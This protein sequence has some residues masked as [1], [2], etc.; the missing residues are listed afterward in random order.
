M[1]VARRNNGFRKVAKWIVGAAVVAGA[2][3]G[4]VLCNE[5]SEP[6]EAEVGEVK[7]EIKDSNNAAKHVAYADITFEDPKEG[8]RKTVAAVTE[9]ERL[10]QAPD[11]VIF[12]NVVGRQYTNRDIDDLV[13]RSGL[14]GSKSVVRHEL[15]FRRAQLLREM[16]RFNTILE[17]LPKEIAVEAGIFA[18]YDKLPADLAKKVK[19]HHFN[20]IH[21]GL[22]EKVS[23]DLADEMMKCDIYEG[24]PGELIA[25]IKESLRCIDPS[26]VIKDGEDGQRVITG[27]S[28]T[29]GI[30][31]GTETQLET[32]E[33]TETQ[34]ETA[35]GTETQLETAEG[36]ETQ[37]ETAE[38]TETQLE[39]AEGTETQLETAEGTETQ[40]ET[41][42]GT[43]TQLETA[44][45]TETQ[46]E[47]AEGTETQLETDGENETPV[48][49]PVYYKPVTAEQVYRVIR[50][51]PPTKIGDKLDVEISS[52]FK[53]FLRD[54]KRDVFSK[55]KAIKNFR[56]IINHITGYCLKLKDQFPYGDIYTAFEDAS[57]IKLPVDIASE[58]ASLPDDFHGLFPGAAVAPKTI[59]YLGELLTENT[60]G[61]RPLSG[62]SKDAWDKQYETHTEA[63]YDAIS[64]I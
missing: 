56:K 53:R 45:G 15:G 4:N 25:K 64:V 51:Y 49:K 50:D 27:T 2:A 44:E 41:A 1:E 63:L 17:S 21:F 9:K 3:S 8:Y 12:R 58:L 22:M 20:K 18:T 34:L 62:R 24:F 33:G 26:T 19:W 23:Q 14:T 55:S 30:A 43:E 38:G 60:N 42:E 37:L 10:L 61:T 7:P 48:S 13:D 54:E 31:E 59:L 6:Q 52:P 32:A 16:E 57:T 40:L 46:L 36:T 5:V 11:A 47:T 39:T 35:E 28:V 29:P